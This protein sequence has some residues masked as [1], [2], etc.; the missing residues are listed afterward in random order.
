MKIAMYARVSSETQAKD[1]TIDSQ[2]EALREYAKANNLTIAFE[3]LDDGY[4]GT[5]LDRPGLDQVRDLAQAGSIDGILILSLDRLSRKQAHQIILIE[6]FKKQNIQLIFTD[7]NFSDTPEDNLMFQIQ[8][9]IAEYERTKILDRMRR[10]MIYS[11]KKGQAQNNPPVGYRYIPR[12]KDSVGYWEVNP[13]EAKIVR[14]IYDLYIKHELKGTQIADRLNDE[15]IPCRGTKWWSSR[16]YSILKNATYTGTAY[17]FKVQSVEPKKNAK[18]NIYRR[19]KKTATALRP[20]E[21]W[22]EIAVTPIIDKDTWNKAQE[23]LKQN[24]YR[25][26]RNNNKHAYLLRGLVVCGVCGCMAAGYV[27]NKSTYYSCGAKRNKNIASKPHEEAIQVKHKSF[28]Q[29]VWLGLTELLTNP[30]NLKAQLEKR[31][32][33]RRAKFSPTQ[34]TDDFDKELKQ[35]AAQEKRILD[36]YREE[37]IDMPTLKEQKGMIS[38]R[39]KV[40]ETKKKAA[41]SRSE[42]LGQPQITMDMLGDVSARFQ[43]ITAKADFANR[44]KLVNLLVN[45]ITLYPHR[46]VVQGTIPLLT[47]DALIPTRQSPRFC[48][49]RKLVGS[50]TWLLLACATHERGEYQTSYKATHVSHVGNAARIS[51]L[52][53]CSNRTETIEDLQ[54]GPE[55][56]DHKGRHGNNAAAH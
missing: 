36:A 28:D 42:G 1:G 38:K 43:R 24:A 11:V 19:K 47:D 2:I 23:L 51:S 27:S 3:C 20:R 52:F 18:N 37:I 34:S 39:R 26:R 35:L 10:G 33:A 29:K 6:E 4:S 32:Q 46:A 55:P 50:Q 31:L 30:K 15:A 8:G 25:A 12:D 21:E 13:D 7:Q 53:R 14:Y 9:A 41:L 48:Y 56:N 16:I 5:T 49:A 17:R 54:H 45:S 44:E 22:F 40:L